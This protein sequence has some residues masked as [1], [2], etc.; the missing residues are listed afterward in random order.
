MF[1]LT[2]AERLRSKQLDGYEP[3]MECDNCGNELYIGDPYYKIGEDIVCEECISE[4]Q[5]IVSS[6][7]CISVEE[8]Y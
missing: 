6:E 8:D 2:S 1:G 7:D 3:V 5:R 4:F